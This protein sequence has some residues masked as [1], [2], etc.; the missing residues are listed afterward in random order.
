MCAS[1]KHA[2]N[3][4]VSLRKLENGNFVE[5]GLDTRIV[6]KQIL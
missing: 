3:P 5:P 6:V 1:N 2:C 4:D